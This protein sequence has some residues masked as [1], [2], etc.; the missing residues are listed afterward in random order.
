LHQADIVVSELIYKFVI[1]LFEVNTH[2]I[3][4]KFYLE[5]INQNILD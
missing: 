3:I 2:H 1:M 4:L 5:F